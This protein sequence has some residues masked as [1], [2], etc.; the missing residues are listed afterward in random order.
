[1]QDKINLAE[2]SRKLEELAKK[3][4]EEWKNDNSEV[5]E[6]AFNNKNNKGE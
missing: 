3:S 4:F 1:M 5:C 2:W 6:E